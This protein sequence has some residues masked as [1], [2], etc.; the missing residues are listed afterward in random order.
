[1]KTP[2][3]Q[4]L[5]LNDHL[6]FSISGIALTMLLMFVIMSIGRAVF[7]HAYTAEAIARLSGKP[8]WDFFSKCVLFDLKYAAQSCIPMLLCAILLTFTSR[9]RQGYR[10]I[11]WILNLV[12][13]LYV[14]LLE[15]INYYYY[16]TYSRIIDVFFF[17]FLKEDPVAT[18]ITLYQDY[19]LVQGLIAIVICTLA[20]L[21][22]YVRL[23]GK[24]A[25]ALKIPARASG[26]IVLVVIL[27]ALYALAIRGSL[28]TFPLR[29]NSAQVSSDPLVNLSVP[30]GP[31][32]L[33][34]AR[35][36]AVQQREVPSVTAEDIRADYAA[37][38][39]EPDAEDLYA[40]LEL[41]I[42]YNAFREQNPPDIVFSVQESMSTHMFTYDDEVKRDLYGALRK[43]ARED[44][45]SFNFLSEGNGTMDSLIRMLLEVPDNNLSTSTQGE[46][47][48]VTNSLK[49]FKEKGYRIVFVT[50]CQGSWR[51]MNTYFRRI[52]MDEIYE[53]A[54]LQ[55]WYD[56]TTSF[57]WGVDDEYMWRGVLKVLREKH[58]QP[59]LVF[60]LSI[61][62]HPP[63]RVAEN[64]EP[65]T[66]ALSEEE[67]GRFPYPNTTTLFA[68]FRYANDQYGK[69]IDAVKADPELKDHVILAATGDHNMRG[70]G[71]AAH[72]DEL[73]LGY[74]V[75]F[76]MYV[77]KAYQEHDD[78]DF[79]PENW[80]SQKDL[81]ATV[82]SHT[83]S[84]ARMHT[85]G[86]D[87]L[88]N[89]DKCRFPYAF[90]AEA[91]V[92]W[93]EDHVCNLAGTFSFKALKF[94]GDGL[95]TLTEGLD[96][97]GKCDGAEALS[98]LEKHLYYYQAKH[99][100]KLP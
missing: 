82:A 41:E 44:F 51:D 89:R 3:N 92:P 29:Q 98:Q 22:G 18:T 11:F 75:P 63:F 31:A 67:L 97:A 36:W 49:V 68:T 13:F 61:S 12:A 24:C 9:L 58:D 96:E 88:S 30:N 1:M 100:P 2:E 25:R 47:D 33:H 46:R 8:F 70:I 4:T 6:R 94:S 27:I 50:G 81:F 93:G 69:F 15:I 23:H 90:N 91:A 87:M 21:W 73:A 57:A 54:T 64:V 39:L 48:Y 26:R 16:L 53:M 66:V 84:D 99:G 85:L 60:T 80:G 38:G 19:P 86:C 83:L 7:I 43:H 17:A 62:N 10:R 52:G 78:I 74:A 71:Y 95:K 77:P 45:W 72:P 14:F 79:K 56:D 76:Y 42:P 5:S 20:Y 37:L 59:L 55:Q 65:K 40:P 34:W 32:A 28:G 35:K